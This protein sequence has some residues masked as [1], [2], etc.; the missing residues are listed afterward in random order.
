MS[1]PVRCSNGHEWPA[2]P[3]AGI[4]DGGKCPV[5]DG[6]ALG[7]ARGGLE[8]T[9]FRPESGP[10][11]SPPGNAAATDF[12]LDTATPALGATVDLLPLA[13]A[14]PLP[15]AFEILREIS[16]GGMGLVYLAR[17]SKL[18]RLVALKMISGGVRASA[19][20]RLRFRI[21]A[22]AIAQMQHPNI[23]Q[24]YEVGTLDDQPFLAL[25]LLGGGSLTEKLAA[26]L[27]LPRETAALVR[28]LALAVH[29]AHQRGIIHR[30]LKPDN[31]LFA[32]DGTPKITDFG[33]AKRL[34]EKQ[35]QTRAGSLLGTPSHM[36][37]EQAM[38]LNNK[39]GPAT[40][41]YA[42]GN[43]CYQLLVDRPPLVGDSLTET[44]DKIRFQDPVPPRSVNPRIPRDL[45]TICLKCLKKDPAARY[46]GA[47]ELAD[48]LGHFLRREPI[49]ARPVSARERAWIWVRRRP[50]LTTAILLSAA[51]AVG[52][53]AWI[54]E[55][56]QHAE[57]AR[58]AEV[59]R[60]KDDRL[61]Q[62]KNF[63]SM[64]NE[65]RALYA[66][67]VVAKVQPAGFQIVHDYR[68][69]DKAIP[70][71]ATFALELGERISAKQNGL[72]TRLYSDYPFPWRKD[73]GPRDAFEAEALR[74]LRANPKNAYY[75]FEPYEGV[76]SLRYATADVMHKACVKCHNEHPDSSKRDWK[77]GDV[78]GVM[79]VILSLD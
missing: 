20:E 57:D 28:Q 56:W 71:W 15:P 68:T 9:V 48:D 10:A 24:V 58:Q 72:S 17:Q 69:Q 31:I 12:A 40:D 79:E 60:R 18:N 49:Q 37:P 30:D 38:G 53:F 65:V 3:T 2:Q 62:A 13:S 6:D 77:E 5:C 34:D 43:I 39:I 16:R 47:Q 76:P 26:G 35:D 59:Q 67:G 32:D 63:Q 50:A 70:V 29:Y 45:E 55:Q 44:L 46:A 22:E 73:G 8:E 78:R 23:V 66:S 11:P 51:L 1:A 54:L 19:E 74:H 14:R 7:P 25:E 64:I 41:V 4:S 36:A 27:P 42:L 61:Q 33:L 52:S 75:R 21:E